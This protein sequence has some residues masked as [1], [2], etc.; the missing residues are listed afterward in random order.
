MGKWD[1]VAQKKTRITTATTTTVSDKPAVLE[2]IVA[3]KAT[4]GTV[5]VHDGP[6]ATGP[7]VFLFVAGL[8]IGQRIDVAAS[9]PKGIAVVTSVA[10]DITVLSNSA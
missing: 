10:D 1:G 6:D 2:A 8:A 9:F 5:T 3:S 7:V 4:T